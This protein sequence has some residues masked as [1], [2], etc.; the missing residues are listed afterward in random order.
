[1]EARSWDGE[2]MGPDQKGTGEYGNE[3]VLRQS[4]GY[5]SRE[6]AGR[7][8]TTTR[9]CLGGKEGRCGLDGRRRICWWPGP[10]YEW[11]SIH[12]FGQLTWS[13][14]GGGPRARAAGPDREHGGSRGRGT[15]PR[16]VQKPAR[17]LEGASNP[18]LHCL[19][20]SLTPLVTRLVG[21]IL[22]V[23]VMR[24]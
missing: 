21:G 18:Q 13:S 20:Q 17:P 3:S 24:G 12:R 2:V 22:G 7:C 8:G 6:R 19:G 9:I 16:I 5:Y 23:A 4:T 14:P 1:L 10:L 15:M 11:R